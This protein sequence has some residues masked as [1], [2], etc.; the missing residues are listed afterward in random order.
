MLRDRVPG[1]G[2]VVG[3]K[4][5]VKEAKQE[6]TRVALD[7]CDRQIPQEEFR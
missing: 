5:W 4:R 3:G 1:S 7:L 6:G 2:T